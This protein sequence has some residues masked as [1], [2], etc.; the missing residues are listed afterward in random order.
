M[1]VR[2]KSE[3]QSGGKHDRVLRQF[4]GN[5]RSAAVQFAVYLRRCYGDCD[6]R[7][8]RMAWM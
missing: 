5:P 3:K 1:N 8:Y 7:I 2:L 6:V 4:K